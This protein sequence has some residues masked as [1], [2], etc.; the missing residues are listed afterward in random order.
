[1][2][3]VVNPDNKDDILGIGTGNTKIKAQQASAHDA[4]I[5]FKTI[6]YNDNDSDY[7]SDSDDNSESGSESDHYEN[8]LEN[9]LMKMNQD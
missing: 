8:S 6:Q 1:M 7:F 3:Y 9:S 2:I 4:L 5:K